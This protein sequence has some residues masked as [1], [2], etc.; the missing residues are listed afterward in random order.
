MNY[1]PAATPVVIDDVLRRIRGDLYAVVDGAHF[2]DA[3][4]TL[5][6]AGLIQ[7]PLFL[8]GPDP[9]AVASGPWLVDL[10]DRRHLP[11]LKAVVQ[12]RPAVVYW[13]WDHG[14]DALYRHLRRL[15]LV[16][17]PCEPRPPYDN[18][19]VETVLFRHADPNVLAMLL[20]V[21]DPAQF[22][23][24]MG[25]ATGLTFDAPDHGGVKTVP[26]PP[27]LPDAPNGLLRITPEQDA[28]LS[29][30]LLA[31]SHRRI[32]KYLVDQLPHDAGISAQDLLPIVRKSD[33]TGRKLGIRTERGHARWAYLMMLSGG[34]VLNT[35]SA[36]KFIHDG[37]NPDRKV[38]E[39]VK[40]TAQALRDGNFKAQGPH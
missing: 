19:R 25:T 36:T 29:Q 34:E 2:D 10:N 20:P 15:N 6:G 3:R 1:S 38:K 17:I 4:A 9:S 22:A 18:R 12:D 28:A 5:S 27:N 35:P 21:L 31:R 40:Q 39:L 11:L 26:R 37:P 8:E 32:A 24:L 14:V 30:Q 13:A 33:E 16:E 7:R 23:R